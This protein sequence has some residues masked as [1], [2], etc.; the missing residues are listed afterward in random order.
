MIA[1]SGKED[2]ID[3]EVSTRLAAPGMTAE[4]NPYNAVNFRLGGMGESPLL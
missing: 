2:T 4:H 3:L 1:P